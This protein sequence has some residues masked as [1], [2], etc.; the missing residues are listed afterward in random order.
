MAVLVCQK[1]VNQGTVQGVRDDR[2]ICLM[3]TPNGRHY[4]E[5][6]DE[7]GVHHP[8]ELYQTLTPAGRLLYGFKMVADNMQ[9]RVELATCTADEEDSI[10][11]RRALQAIHRLW[12]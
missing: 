7:R 1:R 3:R 5:T 2:V 8:L 6:T 9:T 12:A 10:L 4:I 11:W